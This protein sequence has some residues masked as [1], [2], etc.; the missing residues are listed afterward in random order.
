MWGDTH[1]RKA[2]KSDSD[3]DSDEQKKGRQ[4]FQEKIDRQ[5]DR[6]DRQTDKTDKTD[7]EDATKYSTSPQIDSAMPVRLFY[8]IPVLAYFIRLSLE[9]NFSAERRD[10]EFRSRH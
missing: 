6:R 8:F 3:S 2:I 7:T 1:W 9:Q 5:T 10:L 4:V